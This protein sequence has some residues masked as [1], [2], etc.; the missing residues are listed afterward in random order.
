M[1]D[2]IV[3]NNDCP[4]IALWEQYRKNDPA[5]NFFNWLRTYWQEKYFSPLLSVYSPALTS[6][7]ND[8]EYLEFLA[9]Y[10]YGILRP[11]DVTSALRYD[12]GLLYDDGNPYDFRADAGV[13]SI[14]FFRKIINFLIDWTEHDWNVPLLY[15][16]IHDLTGAAWEDILIE[17]DDTRPDVFLV[18]MSTSSAAALFKSLIQNYK[19]I[20]NLPFGIDIEITLT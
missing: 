8:S 7:E 16:M 18:T 14:S 19:Y 20:W 6:C 13:V 12:E 3:I 1:S 4:E 2:H 11:V 5:V 15:K 9:R 17:Q 10:L